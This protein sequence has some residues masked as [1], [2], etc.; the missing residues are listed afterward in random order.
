L[1][2]VLGIDELEELNDEMNPFKVIKTKL[3]I[4]R[5]ITDSQDNVIMDNLSLVQELQKKAKYFK[6]IRENSLNN[7]YT[8]ENEVVV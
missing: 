3:K 8:K 1:F 2:N 7:N 5:I 6:T 4:E